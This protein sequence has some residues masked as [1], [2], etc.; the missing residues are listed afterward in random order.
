[1][2]AVMV[3]RAASAIQTLILNPATRDTPCILEVQLPLGQQTLVAH[4][5]WMQAVF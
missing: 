1:M 3:C 5:P 4:L 2:P